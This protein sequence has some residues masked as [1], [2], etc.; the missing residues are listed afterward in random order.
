M[1]AVE[2]AMSIWHWIGVGAGLLFIV[3][4]VRS[5]RRAAYYAVLCS[6]GEHELRTITEKAYRWPGEG[7]HSV[8]DKTKETREICRHCDFATEWKILDRSGLNGLTM[9]GERWDQLKE[10]GRL[11][12]D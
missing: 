2:E 1:V 12:R 4:V 7:Y 9:S 11:R 5:A 6:R 3:L 10:E 8:A